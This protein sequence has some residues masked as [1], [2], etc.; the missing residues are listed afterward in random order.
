MDMRKFRDLMANEE[1]YF[2]RADLYSDTS[3]GLPPEA[4]ALRVLGLDPYDINDRASLNNHLGFIA[5][6]R[7]AFYISCWYLYT[8]GLET[9]DMWD[10]YG[11]DGVAV[12]TRYELLDEVLNGLLDDAHLGR[13][14]YGTSH[15]TDRFNGMEFITTKE[16]KYASEREVRAFITS[17]DP[18]ATVNRHIDLNGYPHPHPLPINPRNPW[19]P[20]SKRRRID[21]KKLI[22]GV[23]ISPWAEDDTVQEVELWLRYRGLPTSARKSQLTNPNSPTRAE[24]H[25]YRTLFSDRPTEPTTFDEIEVTTREL[26]QFREEILALTP[27]R[28]RWQYKQRWEVLRLY[29]GSIP[30]LSDAQFLETIL[31]VL[32]TWKKR[33]VYM[34]GPDAQS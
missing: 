31:R 22:T 19:V 30:K 10:T 11:Q 7:E 33:N 16:L 29:P 8:D 34:A 27:E 4:Y 1:L 2:R 25:G 5:Q 26:D 12:S 3:E 21:V 6:A 28:V 13:V 20:D 17:Y 32:N 24:L 15:L 9:L 14:Q 23:V 18:L